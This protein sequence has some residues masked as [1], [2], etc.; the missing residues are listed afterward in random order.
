[1][2]KAIS[3]KAGPIVYEE[4]RLKL[5]KP[6]VDEID[7]LLSMHLSLTPEESDFIGAYDSKYRMGM[8]EDENDED[9]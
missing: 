4:F 1:M 9:E 2:D 6:V 3:T 8:V 5:S 7:Q